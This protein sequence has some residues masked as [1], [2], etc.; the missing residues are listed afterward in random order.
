MSATFGFMNMALAE[1]KEKY[2]ERKFYEIDTKAITISSLSMVLEISEMVKA[3][4]SVDEVLKWAE[5]E[6]DKFATYFYANDLK[7]FRKSGRVGGL[8][9]IFGGA[10]GIRP[11]IYM[12]D[13]G[14]MT[15]IGKEIGKEKSIDRLVNYVAELGDNIKD[16]RIILAHCDCPEDIEKI[17]AKLEAKFGKLDNIMLSPVNPT[18]GAHCGPG[19][20]GISFHA[21]H[22]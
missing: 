19:A 1:L 6:V 18:S 22:R 21:I 16:H 14:K 3:G 4:K 15:N 11:I 5:T 10:I 17:V 13:D 2:P 20:V 9:A 12:G 8:A 7:F